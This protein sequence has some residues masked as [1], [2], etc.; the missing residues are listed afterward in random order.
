MAPKAAKR[1]AT[2]SQ[3]DMILLSSDSGSDVEQYD[4]EVDAQPSPASASKRKSG[5]DEDPTP[6][7]QKLPVRAKSSASGRHRSMS[8]EI[9]F[10]VASQRDRSDEVQDS[11]EES[12]AEDETE[13]FKTPMTRKHVKFD[14]DDYDDFVTPLERPAPQSSSKPKKLDDVVED[15]E[16]EDDDDEEDSDDE[17][18]EAVSTH[19][20]AAQ[21]AK[22]AQ[23]VAKVAE[24]Q[25]AAKKRKRRERD[26]LL[27][28]QAESRKRA[29][30]EVKGRSA[31]EERDSAD[32]GQ[33]RKRLEIPDVLP[34]E[35]LESDDEEDEAEAHDVAEVTLNKRIK[36]SDVEKRLSREDKAPRDEQ[37]GGTVYRVVT[38]KTDKKLAPK[39]KKETRNLKEQF[40]SRNRAPQKRRGFLVK[41]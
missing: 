30:A 26:T 32:A 10:P 41:A 24:Q 34:P 28:G 9:P 37:I 8:V 12:D 13:V 21:L 23:A 18:P 35:F 33:R 20:A 1:K 38:D 5:Q 14:S 40:L 2:S 22:A 19:Q 6:K 15:S 16:E 4:I 31:S 17:A 36:F 27:K 7:R 39:M 29:L 11:Q 25:A 3:P